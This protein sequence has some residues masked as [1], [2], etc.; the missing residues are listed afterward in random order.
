MENN[1]F[2]D[3]FVFNFLLLFIK[4]F[5]FFFIDIRPN[6]TDFFIPDQLFTSI[7]CFL[8]FNLFAM[9][10][11]LATSWVQWPK[12]K[13]LWIPVSMRGA[14]LPLFLF[15]NYL[16]KGAQRTL[17]ILIT[18]EW[19]YWIIAVVMSFSSGYLR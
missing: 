17:P 4:K 6:H 11:S 14:F 19:I 1:I 12:P 18:N 10:G 9:L 16:P 3:F 15:C 13:Y 7:T 5:F 8:T 2:H